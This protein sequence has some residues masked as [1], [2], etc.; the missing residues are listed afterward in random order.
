MFQTKKSNK[1]TDQNDVVLIINNKQVFNGFS[2]DE[3][4]MLEPELER[5]SPEEL[6]KFFHDA[7]MEESDKYW[8]SDNLQDWIDSPTSDNTVGFEPDF[9]LPE[10]WKPYWQK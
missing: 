4:L 1:S 3:L 6:D 7:G 2:D 8:N 10:D 5:M 9:H